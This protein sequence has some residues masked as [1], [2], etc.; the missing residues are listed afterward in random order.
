[1]FRGFVAAGALALGL[2]AA[3]GAVVAQND[4]IAQRKTLM[5]AVGD[6]GRAPAAMLKGEAPFNL[7]AVQ[8]ALKAMQDA[9]KQGGALFPDSSKAGDTAALPKIWDNKV[10]FNAK[11]A[12]F[13]A[14]ATSAQTKIVDEASFKASYPDILKNCGGCHQDYRARR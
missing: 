8:S 2:F 7:A 10:D 13:E 1:M 5:K 4:P 6:A 14:D 9:G 3:T 12:K 11:L